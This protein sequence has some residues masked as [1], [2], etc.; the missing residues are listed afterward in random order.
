MNLKEQGINQEAVFK[1][2]G[3]SNAIYLAYGESV[4]LFS[5]AV[6]SNLKSN[7]KEYVLADLGSAKGSFLKK[8]LDVLPEYVFKTI[9]I[10]VNID[11]IKHNT[12][13]QKIISDLSII[14]MPDKSIDVTIMRYAL[15]WNTLDKQHK[16]LSEIKR[17]TRDIA[18]IQH[19]G[20]DENY[21]K[22]LQNAAEILFSGVVPQLER[23]NFFFS[24]SKQVEQIM[25]NLGINFERIQN[26]KIEGL[27]DIFIEKYKLQKDE[28]DK[29]YKILKDTNSIVQSA[30]ILKLKQ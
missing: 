23:I 11:D 29:V 8:L 24:T 26:R 27:S 10:D 5:R 21:P 16:I 2:E 28:A 14:D 1:G 18:I 20:S 22:K 9:A 12:A 3:K 7:G 13:E 30:W 15:A 17:I 19:Q 25:S 6:R 4:V